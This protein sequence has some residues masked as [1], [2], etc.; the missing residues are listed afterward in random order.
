MIQPGDIVLVRGK[1]IISKAIRLWTHSEWSHCAVCIADGVIAEAT[2]P[3][4]Q[5]TGIYDSHKIDFIILR[6]QVPL[7]DADIIKLN[8]FCHSKLGKSYDWR[9][10]LSFVVGFNVHNKSWYFCSEF[11]KEA[12]EAANRPLIRKKPHWST[13]EDIYSSLLLEIV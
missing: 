4:V 13:P 10:L 12:C 6:H 5:I 7:C 3:K 8:C 2:W 11:V 1:G 9:G